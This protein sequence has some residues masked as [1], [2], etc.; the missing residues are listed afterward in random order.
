MIL[1]DFFVATSGDEAGGEC[2]EFGLLHDWLA[3]STVLVT[4]GLALSVGV[5]V[6]MGLIVSVVLLEGVIQVTIDPGK[7]GHMTQE[8]GHLGV[9]VGLVVVSLSDGVEQGL[10]ETGVD[11]LVAG[12]VVTLLPKIF[13]EV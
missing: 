3:L 1:S 12:V 4:E 7:L 5:P 2:H 6:I 9:L 10:V 13:G 8:I 11:D